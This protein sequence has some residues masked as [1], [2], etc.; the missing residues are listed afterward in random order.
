MTTESP[1]KPFWGK[2]GGAGGKSA[3]SLETAVWKERPAL[4]FPEHPSAI[5]YLTTVVVSGLPTSSKRKWRI[6]EP[7]QEPTPL[8][9]PYH[10][11]FAG[12]SDR[13][14][15]KCAHPHRRHLASPLSR[16]HLRASGKILGVSFER[17]ASNEV[18][19]PDF[20]WVVVVGV[21]VSWGLRRGLTAECTVTKVTDHF[22]VVQALV[23]FYIP[24]ALG[25]G[26]SL[27]NEWFTWI[28]L[29]HQSTSPIVWADLFLNGLIC[30]VCE[31]SLLR[32][33]WKARRSSTTRS[34][35]ILNSSVLYRLRS[36]GYGRSHHLR[37]CSSPFSLPTCIW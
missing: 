22:Y 7:S 25:N 13:C 14:P 8:P 32:R 6:T 9:P 1:V 15:Y 3:I 26:S 4:R 2:K 12:C 21:H 28:I 17:H 34:S 20:G 11:I 31:V 30:T 37:F 35:H 27:R 5:S 24:Q 18:I 29:A 33:C 36:R 23:Y 19:R 16:R 10:G